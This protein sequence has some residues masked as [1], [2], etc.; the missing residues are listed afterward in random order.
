M[1]RSEQLIR[2]W[3]ILNLIE[4][5]RYGITIE[6]L[7]QE[8]GCTTR[9]VRRDLEALEI[10]G[11][12]LYTD[13]V[14]G[15]VRWKLL[16]AFRNAPHTPFTLTE[17]LSLYFSRNLLRV[18]KGTPFYDS[19]K[20]ILDKTKKTISPKML[21][22]LG[23]L[24]Q[25][26]YVSQKKQKDYGRYKGFLDQ[27]QDATSQS[28]TVE[29]KYHTMHSDKTT[30]R[31]VDP[32]KMWFF[33]DTFFLIGRCHRNDEVRMFVVDRIKRLT[34]LE[35]TFR[36]P[37]DFSV[38]AYM[39]DSFG[40]IHGKKGKVVVQFDKEVAGYI[41]ERIWHPSQKIKQEKDGSITAT[42]TVSGTNEIKYWLLSYGQ[43][44]KVKE[45][46]ALRDEIKKDLTAA[47]KQY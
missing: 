25:S 9:T 14:D 17:V 37:E 21:E 16:D 40:V 27:L 39:K 45:P 11:F 35:E 36:I 47:L 8:T 7:A 43:H 10:A 32:Y 31:K 2:Q 13:E 29:I 20:S 15:E 6:N 38:E 42:F 5:Y 34:L 24:E 12:P 26:F 33:D 1:P 18:L 41:K 22:L 28:N 23:K 19:I 30:V 46:Q 44:V 4:S 3:G